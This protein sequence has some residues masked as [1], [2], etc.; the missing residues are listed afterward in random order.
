METASRIGENIRHDSRYGFSDRRQRRAFRADK[1]N[2]YAFLREKIE[3]IAHVKFIRDSLGLDNID[4]ERNLPYLEASVRRWCE[5]HEEEY[6]VKDTNETPLERVNRLYSF[7]ISKTH[8][9]RFDVD[10]IPEEGMVKF[11]EYA[12]C[13]FPDYSAFYFPVRYLD[14]YEGKMR[15]T[16]VAFASWIYRNTLYIMPEDCFDFAVVIEWSLGEECSEED[17]EWNRRCKQAEQYRTGDAARLFSE[18]IKAEPD[19]TG[20]IDSMS[21]E[22]R[23][24]NARLIDLILRGMELMKED[25]LRNYTYFPGYCSDSRFCNTFEGASGEIVIPERLFV[26]CYGDASSGDPYEDEEDDEIA[27]GALN[28]LSEEA[29]NG[30]I[31]Q[32]RDGRHLTPYDEDIFVASETPM[33]WIGWFEEFLNTYKS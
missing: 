6:S 33:K 7:L 30:G 12:Y 32:F 14:S 2:R 24:G 20:L 3:E 17:D 28:C 4:W 23:K 11:I 19:V 31:L 21:E 18:I 25:D 10:Y 5:L 29:N 26:F 27:S 8:E 15:Q 9:E 1:P 16:L 22:E 13:D